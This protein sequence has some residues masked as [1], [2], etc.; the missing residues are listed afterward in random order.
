[1]AKFVE[2]SIEDKREWTLIRRLT[3]GIADSLFRL[4]FPSD[5]LSAPTPKTS[6]NLVSFNRP[7]T[8]CKN[9]C[10]TPAQQSVAALKDEDTL[11][12][13]LATKFAQ[14]SPNAADV[15]LELEGLEIRPN[16]PNVHTEQL[17]FFVLNGEELQL[18]EEQPNEFDCNKCYVV[19]WRYRVERDGE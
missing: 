11:A 7:A 14:Q 10:R 19:E 3:E 1:M 8:L 15:F 9:L 18:L 13:D 16:D 2:T 6:K 4:K 12:K 5:N 17:K